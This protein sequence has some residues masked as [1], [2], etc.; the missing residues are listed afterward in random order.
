[1]SKVDQIA[2][3]ENDY[4]SKVFTEPGKSASVLF[5][6]KRFEDGRHHYPK[7]TNSVHALRSFELYNSLFETCTN[8]K[9]PQ[10]SVRG[11]I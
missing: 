2:I 7:T 9:A 5:G 10:S 3:F 1:V 8:R 6:V 11:L 4:R